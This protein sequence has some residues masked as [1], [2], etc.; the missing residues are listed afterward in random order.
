MKSR[1]IPAGSIPRKCD[2]C[3]EMI[4]DVVKWDTGEL[5]QLSGAEVYIEKERQFSTYGSA[6]TETK[7]GLGFSH[8][9]NCQSRSAGG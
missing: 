3:P 1:V 6:P 4:Y 9:S 7:S 2:K 8:L 5:M